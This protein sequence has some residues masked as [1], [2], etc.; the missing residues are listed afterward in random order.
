VSG[1]AAFFT[2]HEG[3]L[4]QVQKTCQVLFQKNKIF[5]N[6]VGLGESTLRPLRWRLIWA[7]RVDR[8]RGRGTRAAHPGTARAS[9]DGAWY[10]GLPR[11]SARVRAGT[12]GGIGGGLSLRQLYCHA[13][14][15][16]SDRG[17]VSTLTEDGSAG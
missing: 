3:I 9:A 2:I 13:Q 14:G 5:L 1:L 16:R 6:T 10:A 15:S 11:Q 8:S 7:M 12:A 17:L 4:S